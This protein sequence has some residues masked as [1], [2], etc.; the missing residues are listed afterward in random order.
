[1]LTKSQID[2]F[3]WDSSKLDPQFL[4]DQHLKGFS[5]KVI[6]S[7][8]KSFCLRY[9]FGGRR[10][11]KEIGTYG[12]MT[13]DQAYR[14]AIAKLSLLREG[15]DP[16]PSKAKAQ[17]FKAN[18]G[19]DRHTWETFWPIYA[20]RHGSQKRSFRSDVSRNK[21]YISKY[22]GDI[23]LDETTQFHMS[24]LHALVSRNGKYEANRV[25]SLV[26]TMWKKA[27][28]WGFLPRTSLNPTFDTDKNKEKKRKRFLNHEEMPRFIEALKAEN[29]SLIR[30]AIWFY[31][32]TGLRKQEVL[33]L[34]WSF[35][36]F[37]AKLIKIPPHLTKN[38]EGH[39]LP[40][41]S[42]MTKLLKDVPR[43]VGAKHVFINADGT[44]CIC[45]FR[46]QWDRIRAEAGL[47]DVRVHDLRRTVGNWMQLKGVPIEIISRLYNH[48]SITITERYLDRKYTDV[49]KVRD[50]M[51]RHAAELDE[52][53]AS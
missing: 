31:L 3:K 40:L 42:Q 12:P 37:K 11:L 5:V 52:I 47:E 34:E 20:E 10:H 26:S 51:E 30:T 33:K 29:N 23:P 35:I 21:N 13:L 36:D 46:N 38:G 17:P 8:K 4:T 19:P 24:E 50:A 45:D 16:F 41:I 32:M 49:G 15:R 14:E 44:S 28:I 53:S 39:A 43:V 1:M 25:K 6:K 22:W 7:G 9:Q 18:Q 27:I 2:S 48:G